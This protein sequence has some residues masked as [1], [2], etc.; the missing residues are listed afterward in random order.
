MVARVIDLVLPAHLLADNEDIE[1]LAFPRGFGTVARP[2]LV[3]SSVNH[4]WVY[5]AGP[6]AGAAV[7]AFIWR[8]LH[9]SV[10]PKTAKLFH[11]PRYVCPFASD[12][13]VA[14]PAR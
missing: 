13:P 10:G 8:H 2:A 5:L 1:V 11:D 14:F 3:F 7:L 6:A 12:L 9:P 4:L